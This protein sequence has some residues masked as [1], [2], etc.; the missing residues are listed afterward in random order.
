MF[1][2]PDI[3]YVIFFSAA[4]RSSIVASSHTEPRD[5]I[6][7]L[8]NTQLRAHTSIVAEEAGQRSNQVNN[9]SELFAPQPG[10]RRDRRVAISSV[11]PTVSIATEAAIENSASEFL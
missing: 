4:S 10:P 11:V 5:N 2:D 1:P 6:S 7:Q 8:T 3:E 9:V